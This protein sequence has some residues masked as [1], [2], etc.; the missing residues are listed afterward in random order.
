MFA[1]SLTRR[2]ESISMHHDQTEPERISDASCAED[3][4]C[5]KM[6]VLSD[7]KSGWA[8][9]GEAPAAAHEIPW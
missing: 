2:L 8:L 3:A 5:E 4:E 9:P 7:Q 6:F 1:L